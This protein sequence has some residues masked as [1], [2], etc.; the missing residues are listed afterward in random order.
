MTVDTF[1]LLLGGCKSLRLEL[2]RPYQ[3]RSTAN[4]RFQSSS[5]AYCRVSDLPLL[6]VWL[7]LYCCESVSHFATMNELRCLRLI[8]N[9]CKRGLFCAPPALVRRTRWRTPGRGGL[10]SP[11]LA[12]GGG[13]EQ[14]QI[15]G[16]VFKFP[17]GRSSRDAIIA[18]C[19]SVP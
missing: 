19:R 12:F 8:Q 15:W 17:G 14:S 16:S 5:C 3:R 9:C 2:P 18:I 11:Y 13:V 6:A 4:K 10:A 7:P 1:A